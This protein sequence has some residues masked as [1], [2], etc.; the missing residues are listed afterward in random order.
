MKKTAL[1][2]LLFVFT[3]F[4]FAQNSQRR[5]AL[6]VG[7]SAYPGG[8]YLKNPVNDANLMATTLRGLG[9]TVIKRVNTTK[10]TLERAIYEYSRK[11]KD[12]DVALFYY[13]G[14][15]IQVDGKNYIIP[16]DAKLTDKTAVKFEAVAVNY[17]VEEFEAYRNH[18]NIVILDACRDNPF[19]SWGRGGARG[20]KAMNP[21]SGTIIAFATSEGSTAADGTGSNGLYTTHLTKQLKVGQSIESVF[22]KTRVAV[23][24]ASN[25]A[26]SPQE[27][28][29]LTGDFYFKKPTGNTNTNVSNNNT[30][31]SITEEALPP[32]TIKL[33]SKMTGS[34]YIDGQNKGSL[35]SGRVYTLKNISPGAHRLKIGDWEQT[36]YVESMQT[37]NVTAVDNSFKSGKETY[38]SKTACSM[39]GIMGGS[40]SMGSYESDDEKPV[41][42][43]RVGNFV[44]SKTEVTV[45][46]FKKFIDATAYKTDAEKNGY[47]YIYTTKWENKYGATW[48]SDTKGNTRPSYEY[49]HPVIHVSWN[50]AT[51]YCKWAG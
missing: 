5:L 21:A 34:L 29:K 12:Y 37:H 47:S 40:F 20:F 6:V 32:G 36:V 46:Q 1:T 45:A 44:M 26:Q 42:T 7:N 16:I 10:S 19:R 33:T 35:N 9:F 31:I 51:A 4:I 8:S 38:D 13:A 39:M 49:D 22:K 11:L 30:E 25:G 2:L 18:T 27:W 43:V 48:K 23:Q 3:T 50:D 24:S 41:H 28:T 15:G 14:H 17:V